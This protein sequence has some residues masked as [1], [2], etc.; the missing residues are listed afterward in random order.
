MVKTLKIAGGEH[1]LE[2]EMM[3]GKTISIATKGEID[4]EKDTFMA[5]CCI[6]RSDD[7]IYKKLNDDLKSSEN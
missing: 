7:A 6:L 3:I 5:V 1:I 4:V 2:S